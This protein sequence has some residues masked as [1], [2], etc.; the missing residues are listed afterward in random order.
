MRDDRI[1]DA[2]F[3]T[4]TP[5]TPKSKMRLTN[6]FNH[7]IVL[8]NYQFMVKQKQSGGNLE[9]QLL[10]DCPITGTLKSMASRPG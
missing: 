2:A 4:C 9:T 5:C 10:G 6:D 1:F 3:K 7:K 8:F